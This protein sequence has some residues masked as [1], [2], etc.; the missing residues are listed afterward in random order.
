VEPTDIKMTG[1]SLS[2]RDAI[3]PPP[4]EEEKSTVA[5]HILW[6]NPNNEL[7]NTSLEQLPPEK[8]IIYIMRI[9]NNLQ[10]PLDSR[11]TYHFFLS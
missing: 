7:A 1:L 6:L 11:N 9:P 5:Y 2:G 4:K 8:K 3:I 10:I